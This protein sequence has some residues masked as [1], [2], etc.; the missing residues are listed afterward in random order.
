M[1]SIALRFA[2]LIRRGTEIVLN[3]S[4]GCITDWTGLSGV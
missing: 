4:R 1:T 3:G 2:Q